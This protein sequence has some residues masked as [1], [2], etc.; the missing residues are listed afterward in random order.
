MFVTRCRSDGRIS[1]ATAPPGLPH[2]WVAADLRPGRL[3]L[4][5]APPGSVHARSLDSRARLYLTAAEQTVVG[6][7]P[8]IIGIWPD[9]LLVLRASTLLTSSWEDRHDPVM[10]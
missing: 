6:L 7:G 9:S 3:R 2:H 8:L 4:A 1:L 10:P 5:E